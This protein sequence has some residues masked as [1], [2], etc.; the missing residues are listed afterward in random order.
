MIVFAYPLAFLLILLPIIYRELIPAIKGLHGDALEVPNSFIG[1][2]KKINTK[3]GVKFGA[4]LDGKKNSILKLTALYLIWFLLVATVARPQLV[5]EPIPIKT[6]SREI[7]LVIDISF[8]MLER[9]FAIG[10]RRIDRL[11]AVKKTVSDFIKKRTEDKIG[12]ILFATNAYLQAPITY[13]KKAV[14]EMLLN[15]DAGMAGKST[16]IGDALGLALKTLRTT[17][18]IDKKIIIL[19]SDGEN[20][21]GSLS[22]PE[23]INLAKKEGIKTY[24]IGVGT[25]GQLIHSMLGFNLRVGSNGFSDKEL[26]EI[27]EATKG[28]YFKASDTESLEKIYQTIDSLEPKEN[29][30][31]FIQEVKELY[32]IPLTIALFCAFGLILWTRRFRK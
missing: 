6:H 11:T 17:G 16:A 26:K 1:A 24:T 4:N 5:G 29:E 27:A 28:T 21:D 23:V 25:E 18:D 2:I 15:T 12:L 8:S 9:D 13:D 3:S 19:L 30:E 14:E 32:Y 31:I 7:L 22:V 10:H 20:N